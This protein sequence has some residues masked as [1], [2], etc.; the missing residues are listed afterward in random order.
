MSPPGRSFD[1]TAILAGGSDSPEQLERG[2]LLALHRTAS[3]GDEEFRNHL[4]NTANLSL[5]IA[6]AKGMSRER[7]EQV[8][9]AGLLHDVGKM[10]VNRQILLKA[11]TLTPDEIEEVRIHTTIGHEILSLPKSPIYKVAAEVA[12]HHHEQWDGRGYPD[13]LAEEGISLESRIVAIADVFDCITV[14][15]PYC[16]ARPQR[17]AAAELERFAGTQFDPG[18]IRLFLKDVLPNVPAD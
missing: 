2:S 1:P 18:L 11:G 4:S 15:R 16:P 3:L 17:D 12:L 6:V 10:G 9:F 8:W 14:G 13:S 7:Q 5:Q